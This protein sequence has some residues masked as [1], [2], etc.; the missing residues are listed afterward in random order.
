MTFYVMQVKPEQNKQLDNNSGG[1]IYATAYTASVLY[2]T[3]VSMLNVPLRNMDIRQPKKQ[4]L[5][6]GTNYVSI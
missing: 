1:L 6:L 4:K 3:H 2:A 5:T